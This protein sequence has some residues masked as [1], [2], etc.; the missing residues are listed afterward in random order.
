MPTRGA[1]VGQSCHK[2]LVIAPVMEIIFVIV[3]LVALFSFQMRPRRKREPGFEFIYVEDD[4]SARELS[5]EE[6]EYL[7]TRFEPTDGGRPYIKHRYESRAPDRRLSGYLPRRQ[8][9][10]RVPIKSARNRKAQHS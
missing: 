6:K 3:A 4:G 2:T 9:P 1:A 8:L 5:E 7:N 10:K